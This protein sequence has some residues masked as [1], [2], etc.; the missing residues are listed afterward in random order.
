M[1]LWI[2]RDASSVF[3]SNE[4]FEKHYQAGFDW[5][6]LIGGTLTTNQNYRTSF[7]ELKLAFLK[8]AFFVVIIFY[9]STW[10][11]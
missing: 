6:L 8:V 2:Q 7:V 10:S 4:G 3:S 1:A 5:L 11:S 9:F